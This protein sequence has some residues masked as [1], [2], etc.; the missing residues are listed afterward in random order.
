[1][2][3]RGGDENTAER[4]KTAYRSRYRYMNHWAAIANDALGNN[5]DPKA[6]W[7][8]ET[9]IT[10]SEIEGWNANALAH[11]PELVIPDEVKFSEDLVPVSFPGESVDWGTT[12][13][14]GSQYIFYSKGAPIKVNIVV[15]DAHGLN[16]S[17]YKFSDY[18]GKIL[19]PR[20]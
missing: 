11:Y 12:F 6:A 9:P 4:W 1:M 15:G 10:R 14:E 8:D 18:Q 7:R 20:K 3:Y 2:G 5:T 17:F 13:Q 19:R 16:K